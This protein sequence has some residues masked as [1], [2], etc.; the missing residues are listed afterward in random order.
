MERGGSGAHP[1]APISPLGR[2][3]WQDSKQ[4]GGTKQ[5]ISFRKDV[6]AICLIKRRN[7]VKYINSFEGN[8]N[9]YIV[10]EYT[11]GHNLEQLPASGPVD[12]LAGVRIFYQLLLVLNSIHSAK[13]VHMDVKP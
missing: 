1:S 13:I 7:I 4:G 3:L 11:D 10:M 12:E 6:D 2:K 5:F 8:D 9:S